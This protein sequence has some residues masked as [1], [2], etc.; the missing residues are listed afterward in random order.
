MEPASRPPAPVQARGPVQRTPAIVAIEKMAKLAS[1][2]ADATRMVS[3]IEAVLVEWGAE[4]LSPTDLRERVEQLQGGYR[5]R[6]GSGDRLRGG[7]RDTDAAGRGGRTDP[8]AEGG[9]GQA[10]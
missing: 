3:A 2:G 1:A 9:A 6:A 7:G 5:C 8:R 4:E 10:G